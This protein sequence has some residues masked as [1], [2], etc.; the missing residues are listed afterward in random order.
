MARI[1]L[2][3]KDQLLKEIPLD[4]GLITVGRS[5]ECDIHIDNPAVSGF[6]AKI[7]RESGRFFIE[8][9]NSTNGTFINGN[10]VL[11]AALIMGD[12]ISIGKHTLNFILEGEDTVDEKSKG[13]HPL[14]QTIALDLKDQQ[15][16][17]GKK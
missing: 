8:D 12:D 6:H 1:E 15:K 11:K 10:R 5:P 4:K 17:V 9:T 14:D 2:K 13:E 7:Y 16:L 3:F